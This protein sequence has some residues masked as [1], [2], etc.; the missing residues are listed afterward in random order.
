MYIPVSLLLYLYCNNFLAPV[1]CWHRLVDAKL[2]LTELYWLVA[3]PIMLLYACF[4]I[5]T[6]F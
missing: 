4:V 5:I 1:V 6:I 2:Q 3:Y